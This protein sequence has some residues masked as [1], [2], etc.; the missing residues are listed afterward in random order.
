MWN[1]LEIKYKKSQKKVGDIIGKQKPVCY[2]EN[3]VRIIDMCYSY[4]L[5][6]DF[7]QFHMHLK[8]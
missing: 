6:V 7:V 3:I 1:G 2:P 5:F 4:Q 8:S